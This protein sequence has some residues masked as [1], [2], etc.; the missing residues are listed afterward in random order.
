MRS[1]PMY[2]FSKKYIEDTVGVSGVLLTEPEEFLPAVKKEI[3]KRTGN[4]KAN[5]IN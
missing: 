3:F 1:L 4:V 2:E 5:L